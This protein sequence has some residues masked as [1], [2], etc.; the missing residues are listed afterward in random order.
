MLRHYKELKKYFWQ[1]GELVLAGS[2]VETEKGL[3]AAWNATAG[4]FNG[5]FSMVGQRGPSL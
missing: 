2:A 5:L 3:G 4:D 1:L